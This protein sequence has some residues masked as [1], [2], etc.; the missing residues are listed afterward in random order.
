MGL[1]NG[2]DVVEPLTNM[3]APSRRTLLV[4]LVGPAGV[5]KSTLASG[6][7]A[8]QPERCAAFGLW[9]LPRRH[10]FA[11]AIVLLPA[12]AGAVLAGSRFRVAEV[13]QLVRLG[14]LRR[15]VRSAERRGVR[16]I[17]L[18]EG[19]VFGLTWLSLCHAADGDA[20]R[21]ALRTTAL[22]EWASLLTA[23]VY[24]NA[25]DP[26][27]VQRIRTREKPHPVKDRPDE[28]INGFTARF[29]RAFEQVIAHMTSVAPVPVLSMRTDSRAAAELTQQVG[30]ALEALH[31]R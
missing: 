23:V 20:E 24:L 1:M 29:R 6:L 22:H 14:A 13:A 21:V 9:G 19:P 10:L 5:G 26:V 31:A 11:S 3:R 2:Q 27:L 8:R 17:V 30:C 28:E 4:E 16:L 18:D 25:D 15:A 7:R 12:L